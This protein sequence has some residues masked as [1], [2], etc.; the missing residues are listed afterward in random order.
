MITRC[1]YCGRHFAPPELRRPPQP[2][3]TPAPGYGW[4]VVIA[5][6]LVIV[7]GFSAWAFVILYASGRFLATG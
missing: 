5:Y 2:A 3:Q 1:P 4:P 6:A 7:I